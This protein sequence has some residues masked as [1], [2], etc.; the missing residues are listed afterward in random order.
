MGEPQPA[1]ALLRVLLREDVEVEIEY[2]LE[3]LRDFRVAHTEARV[4]IEERAS[5]RQI[6]TSQ[7]N[8]ATVDDDALCMELALHLYLI[9][10]EAKV[11]YALQELCER[12]GSSLRRELAGITED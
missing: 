3:V 2:L 1:D 11:F 7:K 6:L 12:R 9:R 8:L 5:V 4:A 10:V